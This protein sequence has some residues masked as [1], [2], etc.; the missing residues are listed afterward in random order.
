[1]YRSCQY[2]SHPARRSGLVGTCSLGLTLKEE[3]RFRKVDQ[4]VTGVGA[5]FSDHRH[6]TEAHRKGWQVRED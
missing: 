2:W 4:Q 5:D 1:M 6:D 3:I